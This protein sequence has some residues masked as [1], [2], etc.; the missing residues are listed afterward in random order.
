MARQTALTALLV[1]LLGSLLISNGFANTYKLLIDSSNM[2]FK[3]KLTSK[4]GII[5]L[6]YKTVHSP[7]KPHSLL[8]I[9]KC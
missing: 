8:I 6:K 3:A 1:D 9:I 4:E 5:I 2:F 7:Y